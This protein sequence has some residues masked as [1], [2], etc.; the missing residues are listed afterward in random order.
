MKYCKLLVLVLV[1]FLLVGCAKEEKYKTCKI[2]SD[3]KDSGY[4]STITYDIYSKGK[5]ISKV[6]QSEEI[7]SDKKEIIDFYQKEYNS[8]YKKYNK[9]YG[10]YTYDINISNNKLTCNVMIDYKKFNRGKYIEDNT[11][12]KKFVDKNNYFTKD[13]IIKMYQNLG[14]NCKQEEVI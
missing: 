8:M 7:I 2:V 4:T 9:T 13:G 12:L 14:A 11:G 6:E 3:E 1:I 10:G 5:I